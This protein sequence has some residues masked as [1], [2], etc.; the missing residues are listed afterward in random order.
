MVKQTEHFESTSYHGVSI[1]TTPQQLIDKLGE[2][3]FF[4]NDGSGKTNM[5]YSCITNEDIFFTIYDWKEY[6]PLQMD[7]E[8]NFH[9]GGADN[10]DCVVALE[11][12]KKMGL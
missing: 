8:Y 3:K 10:I 9:I 4:N 6:T 7:V 1:W 12:L 5:D 2:P 11:E